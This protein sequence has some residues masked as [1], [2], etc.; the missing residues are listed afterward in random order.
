MTRL[1]K[2]LA[3]WEF[4]TT[5]SD[6]YP[7]A[8]Y[9]RLVTSL[10]LQL[11]FYLNGLQ[12]IGIDCREIVFDV[13][14]KPAHKPSSKGETPAH[15]ESRIID[16]IAKDPDR[17][18]QRNQPVRFANERKEAARDVWY[19]AEQIV[20]LRAK[21]FW[22]HN[23]DACTHWGRS[24]EFLPVCAGEADLDDPVLYRKIAHAHEEL[25]SDDSGE[26]LLTQSALRTFRACPRKYQFSYEML[27]RSL[28]RAAPL[29]TGTS[30]HDALG[31]WMRTGGD[32]RAALCK[33]D[34]DGD[35][36]AMARERAMI[37]GYHA[38]W[39]HPPKVFAVERFWSCAL[40][41]PETG[42]AH[43][44]FRLAGKADVIVEMEAAEALQQRQPSLGPLL[45][46]SLRQKPG[47]THESCND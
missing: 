41:H 43:Y 30:I 37:I 10:G 18:Y 6:I 19:T 4:K 14:R 8:D 31:E 12:S 27:V 29:R 20:D 28:K 13:L 2:S 36:Y 3:L 38:R 1:M 25:G 17:Y 35:A 23:P 11:T 7:G 32:L 44:V 46:E 21:G 5:S 40:E 33:L 22:P 24:C 16:A 34:T 15:Y 45:E 26:E 39:D 47:G 9:W 42:N